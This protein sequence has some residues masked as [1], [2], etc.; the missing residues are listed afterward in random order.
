MTKIL[1]KAEG[2]L[3]FIED[4]KDQTTTTQGAL[5][6]EKKGNSSFIINQGRGRVSL[7][8]LMLLECTS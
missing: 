8:F 6:I 7:D 2:F 1:P 5:P 3:E 4:L